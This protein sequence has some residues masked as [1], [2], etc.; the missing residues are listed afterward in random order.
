MR[1]LSLVVAGMTLSACAGA[2]LGDPP[3]MLRFSDPTATQQQFMKDRYA[4]MQEARQVRSNAVV[5][6]VPQ[7]GGV[8]S[9]R[10]DVIISR[11]LLL[12]CMGARG[13][14]VDP[15]GSLVAPPRKP[16]HHPGLASSR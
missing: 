14:V 8:G 12:G 15:K 7:Y 13:Y 10:T 4:C 2:S 1:A 5:T 16:H 3:P 11:P 9:A 6:S